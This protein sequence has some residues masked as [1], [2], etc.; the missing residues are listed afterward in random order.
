[1]KKMI[2]INICVVLLCLL[3]VYTAASKFLDFDKFVFQMRLAPVPLMKILSPVLGWVV[4]VIEMVIAI[5]LAVGFF[6]PAVKTKGLYASVILLSAFE[7]Y[8]TIMLLSGSHLPC[9]C[10]GI[11]SQMGWK[12]HLFF[13][14]FFIIVGILS[15]R[16]LQKHKTS[17]PTENDSNEYKIL[18]RA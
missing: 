18:S 5:S 14:G 11:I 16:Y 17:G 13:N 6:Y 10:G 15:I 7:I 1:M 9:T 8:I 3:F 12:Q 4:P 2:L